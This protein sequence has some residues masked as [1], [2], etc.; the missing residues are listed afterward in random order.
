L[1]REVKVERAL[2]Q[3]VEAEGGRCWKWVSPGLAGVP[4]RICL[5]PVAEEH[6]EIVA[7]YVRFVETK[8]PGGALRGLQKRV[9]GWIRCLGYR[10]DVVESVE[11][12]RK[13]AKGEEL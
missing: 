6:R 11:D 8:A 1:V 4:D 2:V 10:V 3:A 12:A 5:M 13:A 9:I 7:R